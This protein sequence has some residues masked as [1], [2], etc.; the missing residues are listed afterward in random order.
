MAS[1]SP[2]P[3]PTAPTCCAHRELPLYSRVDM[4]GRLYINTGGGLHLFQETLIE[5]LRQKNLA[6]H[7][8]FVP[9]KITA[10]A[11]KAS[12]A[13]SAVFLYP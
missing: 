3:L 5:K 12:K 2:R 11:G 13:W 10:A 6:D 4:T 7:L 9:L 1:A 8:T